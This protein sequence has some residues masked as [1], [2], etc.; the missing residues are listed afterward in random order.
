MEH[1]DD[2]RFPP[3]E[4]FPGPIE[5]FKMQVCDS[6]ENDNEYYNK[7]INNCP[8]C[9]EKAKL[10]ICRHNGCQYDFAEVKC[11]KCG[12]SIK[13]NIDVAISAVDYVINK[14]NSIG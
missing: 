10:H 11:E 13:K 9:N 3:K 8:V 12:L 6:N 4:C 5:F 1:L 2:I 7:H 14:W